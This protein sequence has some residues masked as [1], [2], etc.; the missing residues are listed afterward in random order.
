MNSVFFE[1]VWFE[2][3]GIISHSFGAFKRTCPCSTTMTMKKTLLIFFIYLPAQQQTPPVVLLL[4]LQELQQQFPMT[5]TL[6]QPDENGGGGGR[7]RGS[8]SESEEEGRE[9][10]SDGRSRAINMRHVDKTGGSHSWRGSPPAGVEVNSDRQSRCQL[11]AWD[12]SISRLIS[13]PFYKLGTSPHPH[14]ASAFP[15]S[16]CFSGWL[17]AT[18]RPR[19]TPPYLVVV[20]GGGEVLLPLATPIPSRFMLHLVQ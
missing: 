16:I 3:R 9:G 20:G 8:G 12:S 2:P 19:S 4:T 18:A 10:D 7:G 17:V 15:V 6:P 14:R 5:F 11:A 1:D 13:A